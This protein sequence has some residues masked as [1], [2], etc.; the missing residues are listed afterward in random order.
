MAHPLPLSYNWRLPVTFSTLGLSICVGVLARGRVDGWLPVVAI[1]VLIWASFLALVWLRT[2]ASMLVDGDVLRVRTARHYHDVTARE[3]SE[4]RQFETP[5]GP[6]YRL[7][8]SRPDGST[9]RVTVPAA[10]LRQGH[11]T[12][13]R[14]ILAEAPQ[15]HLDKRSSRTL[16]ELRRRGAIE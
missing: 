6:S 1:M 4:V 3:V 8:V 16:T 7:T 13:F 10:L 15:A 11:A 2:R 5:H 9:C 14:W 12:L